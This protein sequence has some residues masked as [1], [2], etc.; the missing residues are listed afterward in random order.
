MVLIRIFI[1]D[2]G[3]DICKIVG[4]T[5]YVEDLMFLVQW[6]GCQEMDLIAA[7]EVNEKNPQFVIEYY[8]ARSPLI[9]R[10]DNRKL[11]ASGQVPIAST[12]PS[13]N[14]IE[15]EI[16][17][18]NSNEK[19]S[20]VEESSMPDLSEDYGFLTNQPSDIHLSESVPASLF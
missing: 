15:E 11:L 12:E 13:V 18:S 17:Q 6:K 4:A 9:Q 2:R 20:V 5:D 14:Q 8:E 10:A 7:A 3:L 16:M 19:S 1:T